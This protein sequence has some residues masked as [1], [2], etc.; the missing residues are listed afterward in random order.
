MCEE[1]KELLELM[2]K[3]IVEIILNQNDE[4]T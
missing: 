3:L 4:E 2:A 1:E